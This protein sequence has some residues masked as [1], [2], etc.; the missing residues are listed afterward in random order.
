MEAEAYEE[1]GATAGSLAG[2]R[3]RSMT[4][5]A[6]T[7]LYGDEEELQQAGRGCWGLKRCTIRRAFPRRHH[8][9]LLTRM[10]SSAAEPI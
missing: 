9:F 2:D 1:L 8:R 10:L 6:Y 4:I 5:L 7:L 3:L